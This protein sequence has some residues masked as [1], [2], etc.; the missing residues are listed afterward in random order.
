[1]SFIENLKQKILIDRLSRTVSQSVGAPGVSRKI[2]KETMRKLLSLSPFVPEKRR[3]LDLYFR[4]LEPGVGEVLVLDNELP[5][6][7]NTT[8]D[9]VTLRKSPELKEMISIR[10][11]I[12]ILND[13]DILMHKGR[14]T[15]RYVQDRA[16]E[17]LDLRYQEGDIQEMADEG[18]EAFVRGD[19]EAVMEILDLFVEILGYLPMPAEALVND[20]VMFGACRTDQDGKQ[21]FGPVVMYNDRA[22]V[23]RVIKAK[24]PM[25]DPVQSAVIPGVALGEM[26]PDEQDYGVFQFLKEEVLKKSQPTVH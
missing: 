11:V 9:D 18:L 25:G 4:E 8:L 14:D 21:T 10:N 26:K 7:G 13:A 19:S 2:D 1:M 6:Y 17:L 22:N 24:V 12:K 23:L 5:L 15:L 3:D 20:Y 16:L